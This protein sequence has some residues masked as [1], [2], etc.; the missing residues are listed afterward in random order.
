MYFAFILLALLGPSRCV[1]CQVFD[2]LIGTVTKVGDTI[3]E[4]R[5][6]DAK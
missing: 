5:E 6:L 3:N 1:L 2:H 4:R